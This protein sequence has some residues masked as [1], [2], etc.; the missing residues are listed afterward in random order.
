MK[1]RTPGTI[2]GAAA[3]ARARPTLCLIGELA[4]HECIAGHQL[5]DS[6]TVGKELALHA[7]LH[8]AVGLGARGLGT[9]TRCPNQVSQTL[10]VRNVHI[11]T[12]DATLVRRDAFAPS[13][14]TTL[15]PFGNE[16]LSQTGYAG[17]W[18]AEA[19]I[20]HERIARKERHRMHPLWTGRYCYKKADHERHERKPRRSGRDRDVSAAG[21]ILRIG[22]DA[23]AGGAHV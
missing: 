19:R 11:A 12:R 20:T 7:A 13:L 3:T 16:F 18:D 23:L 15:P 21:N 4:G 2:S 17:R 6:S 1:G 10:P 14:V 9:N 22:Q 5:T 8:G